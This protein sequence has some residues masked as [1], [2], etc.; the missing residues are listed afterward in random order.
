MSYHGCEFMKC[1]PFNLSSL[2]FAVRNSYDIFLLQDLA[3]Q[4][5]LNRPGSMFVDSL[6]KA[7]KFSDERYGSVPRFI[8]FVLRMQ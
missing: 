7:K 8:S 4:M 2:S 3:L 1:K 5:L 6:S